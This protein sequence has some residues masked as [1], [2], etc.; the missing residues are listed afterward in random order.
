MIIVLRF[1]YRG[2]EKTI[3]VILYRDRIQCAGVGIGNYRFESAFI[4]IFFFQISP[5]LDGGN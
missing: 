4:F 1:K 3:E 5:V 2:G